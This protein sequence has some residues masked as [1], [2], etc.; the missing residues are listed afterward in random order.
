M[1]VVVEQLPHAPIEKQKVE[2][3]ERK[4]IGHPDTICDGVVESISNA[5]CNYYSRNFGK[6]LHYNVDKTL[7]HAGRS[8]VAF[9]GGKVI[10]PIEIIVSGR[11]T[12]FVD[13]KEIPIKEISENAAKDYIRKNFRYLNPDE[14]IKWVIKTRQGSAALTDILERKSKFPIANDTSVG[15]GYAP[16]SR[17]EKLV[18]DTEGYL[19]SKE[20]KKEFP[21]SGEDIKVMGVRNGKNIEL[22]IAMA[23]IDSLVE[24][25]EDYFSKKDEIK[26]AIENFVNKDCRRIIVKLNTLD[27]K[28]RGIDGCYLTVTG[29]SAESGDDGEV[30]RGNRVNGV[31]PF[32]RQM[33]IEASAGKNTE[34]HTGKLYS[35]LAQRIAEKIVQIPEIEESYVKI[36]S[37]IGRPINEPV[38]TS[39]QLILK[40]GIK[41]D[42]KTAE[43]IKDLVISELNNI[44]KISDEIIKGNVRMF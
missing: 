28:D 9:G 3:V 20:F 30:G 23:M 5:L 12:T 38:I 22:T 17:L 42:K 40:D 25:T 13:H 24:S 7:L 32:G 21:F 10:E 41:L 14:H 27:R 43:E 37:E 16:L 34:I 26:D 15:V 18:V 8:E 35:V 33:S 29:T 2:I 31:I 1:K 39:C 44:K 6:I 11:A 36:L 19:N 4:G